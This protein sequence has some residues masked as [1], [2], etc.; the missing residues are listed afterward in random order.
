MGLKFRK[1]LACDVC[2]THGSSVLISREFTDPAVWDFVECYYQKRV[3]KVNLEGA[4]FEVRECVECGFMWQSEVLDDAGLALLYDEWISAATSLHKK[5]QADIDLFAKYACE[6]HSIHS[7]FNCPPAEIH[8]LDYG[9]GWGHWCLMSRAFGF[10][11]WGLEMS[12]KRLQYAKEHGLQVASNIRELSSY[13]FDFINSEQVFE[14]TP[15]PVLDL[16]RLASRLSPRG[17]IRISV[18]NAQLQKHRLEDPNW[19]AAHDSFHPLEHVNGFTPASLRRLARE[20]GLTV[21]APPHQPSFKP[22]IRA[23]LVA[24]L[25]PQLA[26]RRRLRNYDQSTRLFLRR[27]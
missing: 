3:E 10:Q 6:V 19:K 2:G 26:E 27:L 20:A 17:V 21:V 22:S 25:F 9:M 18:P 16:R 1:R 15:H 8:V 14:H 24:R 13:Q 12:Q 11:V 4:R 5:Q 23:A 7:L